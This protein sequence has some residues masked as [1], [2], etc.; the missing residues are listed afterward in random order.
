MEITEFTA[1]RAGVVAYVLNPPGPLRNPE[2]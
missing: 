1:W 2:P